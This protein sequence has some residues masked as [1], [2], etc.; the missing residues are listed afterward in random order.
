M[1][2]S[3]RMALAESLVNVAVGYGIAAVTQALVFFAVRPAHRHIGR[4]GDIGGIFT[5]IPVLRSYLMRRLIER[6]SWR[7]I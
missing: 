7:G 3:R 6:L 4:S 5:I 2:Q 1:K